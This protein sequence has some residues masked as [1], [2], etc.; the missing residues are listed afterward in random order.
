MNWLYPRT[1][2]DMIFPGPLWYCL[3]WIVLCGVFM[4]G[5]L[6]D[7]GVVLYK[8]CVWADERLRTRRQ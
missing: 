2:L 3:L 6:W 8:V 5:L 4:A 1:A 7:T